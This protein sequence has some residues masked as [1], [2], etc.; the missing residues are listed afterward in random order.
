MTYATRMVSGALAAAALSLSPI[1]AAETGYEWS[2]AGGDQLVFDVYRDGKEFGSHTVRFERS[3]DR[4]E[5]ETDIELEVKFGPLRVFHYV[6]EADEVWTGEQLQSIEA[7]TKQD[8][9]WV[10]VTVERESGG[11]RTQGPEFTGVHPADLLPSSHWNIVQM[12]GDEML[13]TET[14]E[15]LPITVEN[16]GTEMVRVGDSEVEATHY[17]VTSDLVASFWYDA[18]GRWVKCAFEAR[19]SDIEYVLRALPAA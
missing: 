9:D 1:A 15:S 19:G 5:V 3:G 4:L 10:D 7:R 12:R 11:L 16:L 2:P 17:R 13:S 14:G 6:H 18:E 8:G